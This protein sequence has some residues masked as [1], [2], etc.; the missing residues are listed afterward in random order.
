MNNHCFSCRDFANCVNLQSSDGSIIITRE[1]TYNGA[2]FTLKANNQGGSIPSSLT[3]DTSTHALCMR[4]NNGQPLS[5]VTLPADAAQ[6][7][8]INGSSL[9]IS[10]GNSVTLPS[11][12]KVT[13]LNSP[14]NVDVPTT[15]AVVNALA[16]VEWPTTDDFF[17]A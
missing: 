12:N 17:G 11:V 1:N 2:T 7:L 4:D 14:N 15:Q 5:C 16:D 13:N 8:A 3:F 6:T 9:S 10:G